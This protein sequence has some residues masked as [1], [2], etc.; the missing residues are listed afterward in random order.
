M[1]G[2]VERNISRPQAADIT[3]ID[4]QPAQ[5]GRSLFQQFPNLSCWFIGPIISIRPHATSSG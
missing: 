1:L 2:K 5:L 4:T 3:F